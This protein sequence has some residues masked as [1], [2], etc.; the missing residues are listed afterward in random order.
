MK[1]QKK[2]NA[3]HANEG[4]NLSSHASWTF[5]KELDSTDG[6]IEQGANESAKPHQCFPFCL[7]F[8]VYGILGYHQQFASSIWTSKIKK[9]T[10]MLSTGL[11]PCPTWPSNNT[12][13]CNSDCNLLANTAGAF[14]QPMSHF[15]PSNNLHY[16]IMR[17]IMHLNLII[18][19]Q[20][21]TE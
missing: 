6:T 10:L 21:I 16:T 20:S 3:Q 11:I 7:S 15:K 17:P 2:K 1:A 8:Y 18:V 5:L 14:L 9:V 19:K 4:P 12:M 13:Q